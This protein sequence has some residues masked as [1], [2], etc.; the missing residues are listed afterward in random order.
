MIFLYELY[1]ACVGEEPKSASDIGKAYFACLETRN[2][3]PDSE[4]AKE[5]ERLS[6]A[7]LATKPSSDDE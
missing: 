7:V 5:F 2:E 1:K 6:D 4:V 3:Q